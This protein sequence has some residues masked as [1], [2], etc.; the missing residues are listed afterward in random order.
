MTTKPTT[1]D[2][3]PPE[4][5]EEARRMLLYVA[6]ILGDL[7]DDVVVVGGLV[8]YLIVDQAH[9]PARHRHVGT[10]DLDLGLSIAILDDQR[11][12]EIAERLRERGFGQAVNE[13][14]NATRQ[15]WRLPGEAI[16]LDFLIAPTRSGQRPG[17]LQNLEADFA[18]IVMPALSLAFLDFLRITIDDVTPSGERARRE[19][20]VAGPAAFVSMKAHAFRVR[21][22]NKDAYDL[23]YVLLHHGQEPVVSVAEAFAVL[24]GE[25]EAQEALRFLAEDFASVDHV[26]PKRHAEFLG[27]RDDSELRQDALG[28]VQALLARVRRPG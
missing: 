24:A 20:R 16:T 21:G 23:V 13:R 8:P 7:L 14:G 10:R 1:A 18:A 9:M 3:Y 25:S 27:A 26:G 2:G 17:S 28:V 19:V 11:Y 6:T 22:A 5:A 15:T 12:H 4:L